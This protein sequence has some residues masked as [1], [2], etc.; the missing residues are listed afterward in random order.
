[1]LIKILG[2]GCSKCNKLEDN[3][4]EALRELGIDGEIEK[5]T[6]FKEIMEYGVMQTPALVIDGE[7]K[8]SGRLLGVEE[9]KEVLGR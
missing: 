4:R 1:M 6:D 9:I 3:A 8:G 2:T 7:V 5:V